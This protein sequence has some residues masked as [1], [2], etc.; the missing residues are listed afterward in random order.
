MVV[1]ASGWEICVVLKISEFLTEE[2]AG[3]MLMRITLLILLN[4]F[5]VGFPLPKQWMVV[6][7]RPDAHLEVPTFSNSS[8][9]SKKIC[10]LFFLTDI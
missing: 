7:V 9:T 10:N 2:G 6:I 1:K 8:S 4:I 3:T 5:F